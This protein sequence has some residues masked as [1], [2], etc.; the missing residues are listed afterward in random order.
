MKGINGLCDFQARGCHF[1]LFDV[2][3]I[4]AVAIM[5]HLDGALCPR[6][7]ERGGETLFVQGRQAHFVGVDS[8]QRN[9]GNDLWQYLHRRSRTIQWPEKDFKPNVARA[10]A[11]ILVID[12]D[13]LDLRVNNE[14]APFV[15]RGKR[16]LP[17]S[18]DDFVS[19]NGNTIFRVT[20]VSRA[21]RSRICA[22]KQ[23]K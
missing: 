19:G 14:Q 9:E 16:F 13:G 10:V 6:A 12:D 21:P 11:S 8:L 22:I 18:N 7:K 2:E 15:I 4:D 3:F 1:R 20:Q 5:D 17:V 23:K